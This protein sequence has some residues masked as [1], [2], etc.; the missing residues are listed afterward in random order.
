MAQVDERLVKIDA[1]WKAVLAEEFA[2][3]YFASLKE[4]LIQERAQYTIYPPGNAIFSAFNRTPFDQVKVVI[5]G[6]D[7]YHGPGQANGLSFSVAPGVKLPPSLANMFK[8]IKSDLELPM[9][10]NGDLGAWAD[11]GV[12]LLNATLTVRSGMP[13]SHKGKG[14]EQ[15]TDSVIRLLSE[16]REGLVFLL[17]GKNAQQKEKLIDTTKHFVLK[18]AHP[19]PLSAYNG[20]FGCR[21]FSGANKILINKGIRPIHW[22]L[23]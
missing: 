21:H 10:T 14:W 1:S 3:P 18:A 8:E 7:P 16:K 4:F 2:S 23:T 22:Q 11:Q 12:L 15:F 20:F 13:E 9:G 5:M 19:S 6:Q 17:W